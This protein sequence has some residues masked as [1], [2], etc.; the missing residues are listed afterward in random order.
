[1]ACTHNH[2]DVVAALIGA[3]CD[4]NLAR[5]T[6]ATPLYMACERGHADVARLLVA[7]EADVNKCR[8]DSIGPLHNAARRPYHDIT[9]LLIEAQADVDAHSS[10][11]SP[12]H[13]AAA[14]GHFASQRL[15]EQAGATEWFL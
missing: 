13:E 10:A 9:A 3:A 5:D 15:L 4:V 11:S 1:M 8:S 2:P 6:G 14:S 7:A 12:L